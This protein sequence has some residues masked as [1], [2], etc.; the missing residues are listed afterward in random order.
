[1]YLSM[2]IA[3]CER[4]GLVLLALGNPLNIL[5]SIMP[6]SV[7]IHSRRTMLAFRDNTFSINNLK[8]N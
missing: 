3:A 6:N 4:G 1:M 2:V 8:R 7:E 5:L